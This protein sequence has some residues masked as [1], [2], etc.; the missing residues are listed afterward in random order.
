MHVSPVS[1]D[2]RGG[3][4]VKN[5]NLVLRLEMPVR[6]EPVGASQFDCNVCSEASLL[7]IRVRKRRPPLFSVLEPIGYLPFWAMASDNIS[8]VR[9]KRVKNTSMLNPNKNETPNNVAFND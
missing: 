9:S 1:R 7:A 8:T 4:I 6:A 3:K 2:R 5:T